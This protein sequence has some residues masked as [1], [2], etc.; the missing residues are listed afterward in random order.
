MKW[1]EGLDL[2]KKIGPR[3]QHAAAAFAAIRQ[4]RDSQ[5]TA[6]TTNNQ[7]TPPSFAELRKAEEIGKAPGIRNYGDAIEK[8]KQGPVMGHA[9]RMRFSQNSRQNESGSSRGRL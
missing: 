5:Q 1:M 6:Q 9:A 4:A 2:G 7:V 8:G 3:N